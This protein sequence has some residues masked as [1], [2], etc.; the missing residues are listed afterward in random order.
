MPG[1][2][3]KYTFALILSTLIAL[4]LFTACSNSDIPVTKRPGSFSLDEY[5]EE[6]N[7]IDLERHRLSALF[8]EAETG[9]S[10]T[11]IL[12]TAGE[13]LQKVI[14]DELL[15]YWYGTPWDFNGITETPGEGKIACGYLVTTI[16]RDA[17]L[18]LQRYKL[19]QQTSE[20]MIKSL[21][22]DENI[23]RFS[24][25]TITNFVGTLID[26]GSGIYIV[27]L[28][29]HT[30]FIQVKGDEVLFIHSS[31]LEPR[32]VIRERAIKSPILKS[33][34]YRITGKI[35]D[36]MHFLEGWLEGRKFVVKQR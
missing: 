30:G 1:R 20:T 25:Y 26:S 11:R 23:M 7:T 34:R 3:S 19:A 32:M 18:R 21:V 33:S 36:D 16:L 29:C 5:P 8:K 31:Y 22:S 4:I 17:G 12:N 35:T 10:R 6:K 27:G 28:D 15:P 24:D 2:T 9:T 13:Y 14:A